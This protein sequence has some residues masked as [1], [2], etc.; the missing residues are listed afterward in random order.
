MKTFMEWVESL[1]REPYGWYFFAVDNFTVH[2]FLLDVRDG[3]NIASF[4]LDEAQ[5][6]GTP[7]GGQ[8]SAQLH[9]AHTPQGQQHLHVYAKNNQ[10]FALNID[11]KAHDRSHGVQIPNNVADA[12]R[13]RFPNFVIPQNN[14]IE[15]ADNEGTIAAISTLILEG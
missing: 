1:E 2:I 12:I 10:L 7:L 14:Y 8:Y 11:G 13:S 15:H 5:H 6:R 4:V 3:Q 9:H